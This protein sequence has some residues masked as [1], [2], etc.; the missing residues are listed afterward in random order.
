[1]PRYLSKSDFILARDCPRKLYYK[2]RG[3]PSNLEDNE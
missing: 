1:M 2:K 3:Y